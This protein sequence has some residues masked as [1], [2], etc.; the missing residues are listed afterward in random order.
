MK[1]D[2]QLLEGYSG[3]EQILCEIGLLVQYMDEYI[4]AIKGHTTRC[5]ICD[6]DNDCI[7]KH[8][9]S[10]TG[11]VINPAEPIAL[12]KCKTCMNEKLV[13]MPDGIAMPV[14]VPR[15]RS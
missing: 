11:G 12:F 4:D 9:A 2:R 14:P 15:V 6:G 3:K 13:V 7:W 5:S 10:V 1:A 8:R